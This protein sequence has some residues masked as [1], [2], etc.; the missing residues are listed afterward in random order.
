M[1]ETCAGSPKGGKKSVQKVAHTTEM[2][3]P[4]SAFGEGLAAS[5]GAIIQDAR[6]AL[7]EP[8]LT[9][10]EAVHEV[11]K[12]LKRW[13]ALMRLLSGAVGEQA[14]Q[15][16]TEAR[17]LM[18]TLSM[19]RNAQAALDA[20]VDLGKSKLPF[21]ATSARTMEGRLTRLRGEAEAAGLTP[22]LRQR[23]TQYLDFAARSVERWPLASIPFGA[24]ADELALT[25][26]RARQLIPDRWS[27]AEAEELHKLRKRVVEHR[28]QMELLEPLWPKL[29][30]LWAEETQRLR[31]RLGACQDLAVLESF[32]V[33]HCPLAPWRAKLAPLIAERRARHLKAAAKLAPRLFAEKPKAFRTRIGALWDARRTYHQ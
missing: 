9:D 5:A 13:R 29:A 11:R 23:M 14:D 22:E 24:I 4:G 17:D 33:P 16:R 19:T 20:L 30:R 3:G 31:E 25:Y 1:A 26:R 32:T 15:M 27:E 12:A 28:H 2:P 7:S 18:R 21:S 6:S 10:A 8:G